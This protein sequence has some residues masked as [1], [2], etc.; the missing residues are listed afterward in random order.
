MET[1]MH[2][3]LCRKFIF[4]LFPFIISSCGGGDNSSDENISSNPS[5]SSENIISGTAVKGIIKNGIVEVYGVSNGQ[6][7]SEPLAESKTDNNGSYSL[8]VKNYTGPLFV[9]ITADSDTK[10]VCDILPNCGD[11]DFGE[12]IDLDSEF[13]I[14]SVIGKLEKNKPI[15]A[16]VNILTTL[17]AAMVES[18][19]NIDVEKI[20][21]ANSQ[22]AGIFD[23]AGDLSSKPIVDIT[24]SA[25]LSEAN[26]DTIKL[27]SLNSAIASSMEKEIGI[28]KG[29]SNLAADFVS[30]GGQ[31]LNNSSGNEMSLAKIYEK[32]GEILKTKNFKNLDIGTLNNAADLKKVS[33]LNEPL[34][35]LTEAKPTES[36]L[37]SKIE[38]AMEMVS[39]IRDFSLRSTYEN[40]DE[41]QVLMELDN[42]LNLVD[43]DELYK[44]SQTLGIAGMAL[45]DAFFE[46]Y[47][48]PN[49]EFFEF[50]H[51]DFMIPVKIAYS[52]SQYEF[53]IN[54]TFDSIN[55]DLQASIQGTSNTENESGDL[56]DLYETVQ[57]GSYSEN[58]NGFLKIEGTLDGQ[59]L[60]MNLI[61]GKLSARYDCNLIYTKSVIDGSM[62]ELYDDD[63]HSSLSM[64][65]NLEINSKTSNALSFNGAMELSMDMSDDF[66]ESAY[67]S[68][69]EY[70]EL[71]DDYYYDPSDDSSAMVHTYVINLNYLLSGEL[72]S[73]E[74]K[75]GFTISS[76]MSETDVREYG[77]ADKLNPIVSSDE[78]NNAVND[79]DFVAILDQIES[80]YE[81]PSW[82]SSPQ[83][84]GSL[85]ISIDF[86]SADLIDF[87]GIDLLI[88]GD[89][90]GSVGAS[91]KLHLGSKSLE[92]A[93]LDSLDHQYIVT[94]Q[95]GTILKLSDRCYL[96]KKGCDNIG[97][98]MVGDEETATVSY[99][100]NNDF[101]I[102]NYKNGTSEPLAL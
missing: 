66:M 90:N 51:E 93:N 28:S 101:V 41:A 70:Y 96:E 57:P 65:L 34:N 35:S 61:E 4:L 87:Q 31:L 64:N 100:I 10:M 45:E 38:L 67:G 63:Y 75:F 26:L 27:T 68:A 33:A 42:A 7:N 94:N 55:I 78:N 53:S 21:N 85:G 84:N 15:T 73:D 19:N 86:R 3:M 9:E 39:N 77:N 2:H 11:V 46:H 91:L 81:Y 16:N 12:E 44:H 95:N 60:E 1:V 5:V 69:D 17:V 32:T 6:K 23:M 58:T 52:N 50:E 72:I 24:D 62:V 48:N 89:E 79:F 29:L 92:F 54:T 59:T 99:D 8:T 40:S 25:S 30:N 13:E 49:I 43:S 88:S 83:M 80:D 18:E 47:Q 14:N 82:D 76:T 56:C 98:I 36:A 71:G 20:S 22:V 74:E 102:V 37:A 97:H